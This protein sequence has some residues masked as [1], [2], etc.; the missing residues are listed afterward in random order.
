MTKSH[1]RNEKQ[2]L[3]NQKMQILKD[4]KCIDI[5]RTCNLVWLHFHTFNSDFCLDIQS[6]FRFSKDK[7]ILITNNDIY[8]PK[9]IY[10]KN[11][12]FNYEKFNWDIQ[13]ENRF[14][15]WTVSIKSELVNSAITDVSVSVY[16]DLYILFDNA[17]S[18]EIFNNSLDECW[19]FFERHKKNHT[20]VKGNSFE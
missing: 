18:L 13:G 3:L 6:A 19:R 17:F 15:E 2:K 12:D 16:G 10:Q 7:E 8:E 11:L 14:D 1:I 20:V 9:K 4:S 5:G